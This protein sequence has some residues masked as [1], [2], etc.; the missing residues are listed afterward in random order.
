MK[1]AA[2]R[3]ILITDA[4]RSQDDQLRRRQIRYVSMMGLRAVCLVLAALLA[5]LKVPLLGLWIALCVAGM[6]LLPWFAVLIA[7]DRPPKDRHRLRRHQ[8][9][10]TQPVILPS[11]RAEPDPEPRV[12]DAEE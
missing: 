4:E 11:A 10:P 5:T 9:V 7:N 1:R 3:P 8:P 12:I 6:V 2:E